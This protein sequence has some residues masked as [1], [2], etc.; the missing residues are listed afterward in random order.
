MKIY[1][2]GPI[3]GTSDYQERFS[4]AEQIINANGDGD[5]VAVNPVK[6]TAGIPDGS[7]WET[8]KKACMKILAD[9]DAIYMLEGWTGSRGARLE[10]LVAMELGL[11][12][13]KG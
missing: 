2:S 10:Y 6:E 5:I 8:Y 11:R 7:P 9:C 13:V 12:E 3:T 1:I 4:A